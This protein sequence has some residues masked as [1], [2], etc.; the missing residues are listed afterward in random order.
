[1][2]QIPPPAR[3]SGWSFLL[4]PRRTE[5]PRAVLA[6]DFLIE[7]N[8]EWLLIDSVCGDGTP[9]CG[10]VTVE[11][12]ELGCLTV[13]CE[14][15][16][17]ALGESVIQADEHGRPL[18]VLYGVVTLGR[19]DGGLDE[20]DLRVARMQSLSTYRRFLEKDGTIFPPESSR[21]FPLQSEEPARGHATARCT[22]ARLAHRLLG[23]ARADRP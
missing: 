13:V 15:D 20:D 19:C 4:A 18:G 11:D 16:Q 22:L 23:R 9:Q 8:R 6:P 21:P 7:R 10:V 5:G 3:P 12:D 2:A 1:M 17:L 14:T